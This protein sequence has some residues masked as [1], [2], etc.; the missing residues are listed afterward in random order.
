MAMP[1]KKEPPKV[2]QDNTKYTTLQKRVDTLGQKYLDLSKEIQKLGKDLTAK[3]QEKTKIQKHLAGLE[4]AYLNMKS[5]ALVV[6]LKEFKTVS[7]S[8]G[9]LKVSFKQIDKAVSLSMD[10]LIL[11][12]KYLKAC[13]KEIAKC[14]KELEDFG[15]IHDFRTGK[16]KNK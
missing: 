15:E 2:P 5:D 4:E 12:T 13:E 14:K 8:V 3:L 6:S 11:A 1:K 10:G 16:T 9:A 7:E